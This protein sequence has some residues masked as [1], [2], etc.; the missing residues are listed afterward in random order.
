M[1]KTFLIALA[2]AMTAAS[3]MEASPAWA[4]GLAAPQALSGAPAE[5]ALARKVVNV[6]GLNGCARVQTSRV[7]HYRY[8]HP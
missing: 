1:Q 5:T 7:V 3:A 4:A 6:C 8:R 2:V